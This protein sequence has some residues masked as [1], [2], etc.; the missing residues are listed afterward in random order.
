MH[1]TKP[2]Q[3]APQSALHKMAKPMLC[4]PKGYLVVEVAMHR[5]ANAIAQEVRTIIQPSA[6][7][8]EHSKWH[9]LE[10]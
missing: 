7:P 3:H 2:S 5:E 6:E 8:D 4:L 9:Q 10:H 1:C